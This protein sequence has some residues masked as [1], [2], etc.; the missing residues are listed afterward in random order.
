MDQA[1]H[2][3]SSIKTESLIE[4]KNRVSITKDSDIPKLPGVYLIT[5]L[6]DK[7]KSYIG[8]SL[9]IRKRITDHRYSENAK[10]KTGDVRIIAR[11]I[12]A[13]GWKNFEVRILQIFKIGEVTK[14]QLQ[15]LEE[16]Y[17]SHYNL[18]DSSTGYNI[19]SRGTDRSGYRVSETTKTKISKANLGR[20][21]SEETKARMSVSKIG[22]YCGKDHPM[23]GKQHTP[24]AKE[25]MSKAHSGENHHMFGKKHTEETKQKMSMSACGENNSNYG[26]S[27]SPTTRKKISDAISGS[28]NPFYGKHHTEQTK[29]KL[30]KPI[31]QLDKISGEKIKL[32]DSVKEAGAQFGISAYKCISGVLTGN[33]KSAYGFRWEYL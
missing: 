20:Q 22:K 7:K 24:Q 10:E 29:T 13:Y 21:L 30:R 19:L 33:K 28:K 25:N 1:A 4:I 3:I 9:D 15:D 12:K 32:W 8:E 26:K 6:I 14:D 17:I 23:F 16:A 27:A 11:A 2:N 31:Y 5:C 18:L